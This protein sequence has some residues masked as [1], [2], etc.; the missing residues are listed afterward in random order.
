MVERVEFVWKVWI[1][2]LVLIVKDDLNV[3]LV[4]SE[5]VV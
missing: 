1:V 4:L 2:E 3:L 5:K